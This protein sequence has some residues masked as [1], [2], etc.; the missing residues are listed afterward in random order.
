MPRYIQP[1]IDMS[2]ELANMADAPS[3]LGAL[4]PRERKEMDALM[5]REWG[6]KKATNEGGRLSEAR[7]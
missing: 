2:Q 1:M 4:S 7:L 3:V 6:G 5:S